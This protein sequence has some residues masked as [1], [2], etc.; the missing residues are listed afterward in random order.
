MRAPSSRT[1]TVALVVAALAVLA[2]TT[3]KTHV[4][5]VVGKLG[6]TDRIQLVVL[7][8]ESGLVPPG[9]IC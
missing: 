5:Q 6:R 1:A 8:H 4:G 9:A 7:A 2:E 3:I